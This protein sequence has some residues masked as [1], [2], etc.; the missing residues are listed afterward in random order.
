M[1]TSGDEGATGD[2]AGGAVGGTS[3]GD[4]GV[5]TERSTD[6]W[7]TDPVVEAMVRIAR[8]R[9]RRVVDAARIYGAAGLAVLPLKW[10][11]GK[12]KAPL[13]TGGYLRASSDDGQILRWWTMWPHALIG[14][15]VPASVVVVDVDPRDEASLD[16]LEMMLGPLPETL[17]VTSGRGDGGVHLYFR[18]PQGVLRG[19]IR[20]LDGYDIKDNGYVVVPPSLHPDTSRPYTVSVPAD[21]TVLPNLSERAIAELLKPAVA[22][23]GAVRR[24]SAPDA[25]SAEADRVVERRGF[26]G[27]LDAVRYSPPQVRREV[28][29]TMSQ[30]VLSRASRSRPRR[31][32]DQL[33]RL[34]QAAMAAGMPEREARAAAKHARQSRH[35]RV[36]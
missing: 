29:V 13:I 34:V 30:K 1:P 23:S 11:G 15:A 33:E 31:T 22:T 32:Q 16:G 6:S 17:T 14:L 25:A 20:G 28:L 21:M 10:T 9:P 18:R 24:S 36:A 35:R 8:E 5:T 26:N 7:E 2:R 19:K 3:E 12:A 27:M 4:A